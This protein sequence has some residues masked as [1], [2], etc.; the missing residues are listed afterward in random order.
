MKDNNQ[1]MTMERQ[2]QPMSAAQLKE[3]ALRARMIDD[4]PTPCEKER[5][6]AEFAEWNKQGKPITEGIAER[7]RKMREA[8]QSELWSRIVSLLEKGAALDP[9]A[10]PESRR[11]QTLDV[12]DVAVRVQNVLQSGFNIETIWDLVHIPPQEFMKRRIFMMSSRR[13][14]LLIIDAIERALKTLTCEQG[15]GR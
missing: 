6:R 11:N 12:L 14:W 8:W 13:W 15:D 4:A 1:Q 2:F 3:Q 10:I 9:A 5:L 7:A